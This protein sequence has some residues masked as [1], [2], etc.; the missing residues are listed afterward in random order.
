[1]KKDKPEAPKIET[2]KWMTTYCDLMN[3]LLVFFILLYMMSTMDLDKFKL[4]ISSFTVTLNPE[5]VIDFS[6]PEDA[7]SLYPPLDESGA[8][9]S[10][11]SEDTSSADESSGNV[12]NDYSLEDLDEFV[13]FI[14]T[15]I[16]EKG[17]ENQII[18]EKVDEY[19]YFR[20]T[21][22]VLFFPNQSL[23]KEGSYEPLS[24]IGDV[25]TKAYPE[26]SH[27][28]IIGHTS[29]VPNDESPIEF[30]SWDLSS[31]R[32]LRVLKFLVTDSGLPK[33]KMVITGVSSTQPYT[34]GVTEADKALN[35]RVDIRL[36]RL[37][38]EES[39]DG[40]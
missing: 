33:N 28:E 31:E 11:N 30:S 23:L 13:R 14:T 36:S 7:A 10:L 21:E 32:S 18:V 29:Y 2:G 16:N 24:F 1:M 40:N 12:D 22:D 27:I 25:L 19:V 17:L 34:E 37:V 20:F 3:N 6:F 26:I 39:S 4:I 15:I 9:E 5:K 8:E 38:D 35:R